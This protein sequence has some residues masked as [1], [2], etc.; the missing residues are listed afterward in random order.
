MSAHNSVPVWGSYF[1]AR[2]FT[3]IDDLEKFS[4]SISEDH[5][6][7]SL[8]E[9]GILLSVDVECCLESFINLAIV[10]VGS[11]RDVSALT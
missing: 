7:G 10:T 9:V 8:R 1:D 6:R 2:F 11:L 3:I 4:C 5:G